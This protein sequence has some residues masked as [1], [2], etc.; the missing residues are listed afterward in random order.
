MGSSKDKLLKN[1]KKDEVKY[2]LGTVFTIPINKNYYAYGQLVHQGI[3]GDVII[4]FDCTSEQVNKVNEII[5]RDILFCLSVDDE[6]IKNRKWKV[7]G[8]T[9]IPN[10]LK[11]ENNY[12]IEELRGPIVVDING[13]FIRRATLDEENSLPTFDS[14]SPSIVEDLVNAKFGNG[15]WEDYFNEMIYKQ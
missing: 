13:K 15:E 6:K 8:E 5:Q 14:Y 7:I 2:E 10:K 11:L 3:Y 12:L 4:I 1:K 9:Q